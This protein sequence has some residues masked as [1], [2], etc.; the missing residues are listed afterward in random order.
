[1]NTYPDAWITAGADAAHRALDAVDEGW[2]RACYDDPD[3]KSCY[4]GDYARRMLVEDVMPAVLDALVKAGV[5]NPTKTAPISL[6]ALSAA[7]RNYSDSARTGT[8]LG[9]ANPSGSPDLS[10]AAAY[11]HA[12]RCVDNLKDAS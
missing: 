2:H 7:F 8:R 1:M 5:I 4:K 10:A 12:A 6:N 3:D 11:E 9:D